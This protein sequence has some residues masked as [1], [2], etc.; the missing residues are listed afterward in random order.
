M[1]ARPDFDAFDL[2]WSDAA[3]AVPERASFALD[4]L[5]PNP[6]IAALQVSYTLPDARPA[7]V[8]LI[9]LAGR[10]VLHRTLES[11]TGRHVFRLARAGEVPAGIYFL[12]L[13]HG[14]EQRTRRCTVL[15]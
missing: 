15:R 4:G 12:R 2:S 1:L 6:T 13:S 5:L 7:T 9:D 3:A 11:G 8:E 14:G 10:P